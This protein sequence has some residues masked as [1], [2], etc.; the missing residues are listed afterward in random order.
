VPHF[1]LDL[2]QLQL[3]T[4]AIWRVCPVNISEASKASGL[5]I[6]TIRF[7]EKAGMLP[8]APR[9]RRGWRV[10]NADAVEWLRNLER[11]RATGMPLANVR[12]FAVLVHAGDAAAVSG[13][14]ERLTILRR[15]QLRLADRQNELDACKTYLAHKIS[16]YEAMEAK[17]Q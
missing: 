17:E 7:Y 3:V 8:A 11:L 10:F 14:A 9:D 6:D 13:T 2:E 4:A 5:S 15:H 1:S 16:V 12:R